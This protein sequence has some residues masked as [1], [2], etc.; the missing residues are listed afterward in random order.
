MVRAGSAVASR[1][2]RRGEAHVARP[3]ARITRPTPPRTTRSTPDVAQGQQR[4]ASDTGE[5]HPIPTPSHCH[6]GHD[7]PKTRGFNAVGW[8]PGALH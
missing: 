5:M 4:T 8:A 3:E 1:C 7:V 2:G 6:E